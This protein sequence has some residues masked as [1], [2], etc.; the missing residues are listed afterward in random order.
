MASDAVSPGESMPAA[1]TS[2]GCRRRRS[3]ARA[4]LVEDAGPS[5]LAAV[6]PLDD[7]VADL[8]EA[9]RVGDVGQGGGQTLGGV[10][11]ELAGRLTAEQRAF[12]CAAPARGLPRSLGRPG[13]VA[14]RLQGDEHRD[15]VARRQV[16]R[17]CACLVESCVKRILV[18]PASCPPVPPRVRRWPATRLVRA[19][20]FPR[21]APGAGARRSRRIRRGCR[22][23][24]A[25][26]ET[27]RVRAA[28]GGPRRGRGARLA[29]RL[30]V[31]LVRLV[32]GRW[33]PASRCPR[34]SGSGARRARGLW[35]RAADRPEPP[36][37]VLR[38]SRPAAAQAAANRRLIWCTPRAMTES[39]GAGFVAACSPRSAAP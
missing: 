36:C 7:P 30:V 24:R 14:R 32:A 3:V 11:V 17:R 12:R 22:F 1:C 4:R 10:G 20:R 9:L 25:G 31:V 15:E 33:G 23:R 2:R 13:V 26:A 19:S 37:G 29:V 27:D 8:R 28:D 35:G 39:A 18:M 21:P 38:P 34:W 16:G 6:S 5:G